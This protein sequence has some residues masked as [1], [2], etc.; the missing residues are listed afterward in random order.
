GGEKLRA[1]RTNC[2]ALSDDCRDQHGAWVA[3]ESDVVVVEDMGRSAVNECRILDVALSQRGN[4]GSL[5]FALGAGHLPVEEGD[6]RIAGTCYH[7]A[8]AI[9]EASLGHRQCLAGYVT[10]AQ[11]GC[12][13]AEFGG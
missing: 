9:G 4:E 1:A 7:H 12:E 2:F 3:V 11:R 13:A 6:H 10:E 5:R 8:E